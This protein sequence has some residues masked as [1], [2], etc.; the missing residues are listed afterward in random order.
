MPQLGIVLIYK[1][2]VPKAGLYSVGFLY[3][4]GSGSGLV[5]GGP[6]VS[7]KLGGGGGST[8]TRPVGVGGPPP[9]PDPSLGVGFF[10]PM[11]A[12]GTVSIQI[13]PSPGH[14]GVGF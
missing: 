9:P 11:P 1:E 5:T 4:T 6:S 13:A 10:N 3:P 8:S 7:D 2:M 14:G 12:F